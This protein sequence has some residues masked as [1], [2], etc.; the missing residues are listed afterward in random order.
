MSVAFQTSAILTGAVAL[1]TSLA[2]TPAVAAFARRIGAVAKPKSDRWH[3]RPTA[4]LGG[5]A[6]VLVVLATMMA[7]VPSTRES[8]IIMAASVGLFLV[9]LA[10]DFF[11]IKPY[12]KLIGQLL[13]AAAVVAFGLV[14]PWTP[15]FTINL[16]ITLFWLVG[17]TNAVNML[18]NMDGLAAGVSAIAATFLGLTFITNGQWPEALM[19][20]AFAGTL[21]GFLVYNHN[22]ASIFMGDCGSM[23]VGF[24]LA[25]SALA[26]GN[27]GGRSRS[28]VAVL[29]VPV[30]V[31][32]VPI[33]D[34]AFVTL[35][36]KSAGRAASQGGRDHT[37]HRLVAL[38]LS[39]KRA[40]WMFYTFAVAA[41]SLAMLVRQ[42][43]LDVSLG[44]IAS[45]IL[46]LTFLGVHLARVRVYDESASSAARSKALFAFLVDFSY[47]RRVFEVGLD[48]VLI[49]LS[50]Y[51]AHALVLGPASES[52]GWNLFFRSL[53]IALALK[54]AAL[55]I[56]GV[57]RGLWRYSS[58]ADVAA[59]A[60]GV[61]LGSAATFVYISF[62]GFRSV[63][64]SVF[65]IDAMLLL[66][67]VIAS[68][69]AFRMLRKTLPIADAKQARR[70]VIYGAGDGGELLLRTLR[71][72]NT[73]Q[74]VAVAF[75][76]DDPRKSGRMLHGL[77]IG[78]SNGAGSIAALCRGY[79]ADEILVAT[80]KLPAA[81]LRQLVEECDLAGVSVGRMNIAIS[82]LRPQ[83]LE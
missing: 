54:L 77:P 60:R 10:D 68:R 8:R 76:D 29:A 67:A 24:F 73:L 27:G 45:F 26:S 32:V 23:F 28:V 48:V 72:D 34:T 69:F 65:V 4:M 2:L 1:I 70:V 14:L 43:A 9:G 74:R 50:Y 79:N 16:L 3:T 57:Y 62:L 30:L 42:T 33:F 53:P 5:V 22:P 80:G 47:K 13:G 82:A 18:D 41:G 40:V 12:Q 59:Y 75:L 39:E 58:L 7:V 66:F 83:D 35:M 37:S 63:A 64:V 17:I 31:L 19:L 44:A 49:V 52:V 81:R 36:R 20:V 21:I 15:Y 61:A 56:G 78:A 71:H 46:V 55:L 6:I 11:H 51:Y 38:G 25:A